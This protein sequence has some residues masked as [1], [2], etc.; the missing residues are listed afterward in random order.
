[1]ENTDS[2]KNLRDILIVTLPI[3]FIL[4]FIFYSYLKGTSPSQNSGVQSRTKFLIQNDKDL[5]KVS[6]NLDKINI[7]SID[8]E[9]K[10]I[11]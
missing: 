4:I 8:V 2:K 1:M 10:K 11:K 5:T 7:E 3:A 6:N 9:L